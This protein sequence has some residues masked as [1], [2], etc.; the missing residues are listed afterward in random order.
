MDKKDQKY[1]MSSKN[2]IN[3]DFLR[4]THNRNNLEIVAKGKYFPNPK[5]FLLMIMTF[6]LTVFAWIFF[7]AENIGHAFNY[8]SEIFSTSLFEIPNFSGMRTAL[9][10]IIFTGI[11]VLIEW[12]EA[13]A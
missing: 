3:L 9:K 4:W 10:T 6:G 11:F 7:R 5:E 2:L 12:L 8:I 13:V 1:D